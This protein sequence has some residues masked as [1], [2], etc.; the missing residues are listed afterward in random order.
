MSKYKGV[1]VNPSLRII[2]KIE[3][4]N[5]IRNLV[6]I[7]QVSDEIMIAR[8]DLLVEIFYDGLGLQEVEKYI[9]ACCM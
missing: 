4:M 5:G 1:F 9:F 8:G 2:S 7:S 6:S 3:S